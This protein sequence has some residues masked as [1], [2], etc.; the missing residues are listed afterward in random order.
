MISALN[1]N[2]TSTSNERTIT[3]LYQQE[4][5]IYTPPLLQPYLSMALKQLQNAVR[6]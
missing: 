2:V 3:N 4:L 5:P 1:T 6:V